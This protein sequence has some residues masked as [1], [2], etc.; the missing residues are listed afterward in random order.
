MPQDQNKQQTICSQ[1]SSYRKVKKR[2]PKK[3]KEKRKRKKAAY[4]LQEPGWIRREQWNE[5]YCLETSSPG[6]WRVSEPCTAGEQIC[7]FECVFFQRRFPLLT[8]R[9]GVYSAP[10]KCHVKTDVCV[11]GGPF[12]TVPPNQFKRRKADYQRPNRATISEVS[13]QLTRQ[14]LSFTISFLFLKLC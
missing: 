8:G 5:V 9:D 4:K 1:S 11:P 13:S 12:Y 2:K 14:H 3:K 7:G 10:L 6:G